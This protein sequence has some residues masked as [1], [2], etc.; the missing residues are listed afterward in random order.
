MAIAAA[1][2]R[3]TA[4][5]NSADAEIGRPAGALAA[6]IA[7]VDSTLPSAVTPTPV[8]VAGYLDILPAA[9]EA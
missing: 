4:P 1:A 3:K 2:I 5:S 6:A 8:A 7:A 9:V